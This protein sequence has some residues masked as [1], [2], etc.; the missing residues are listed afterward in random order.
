VPRQLAVT[1]IAP[2]KPGEAERLKLLLAGAGQQPAANAPISFE[3]FATT[4][5]ARFV[6][7]DAATGP[8]GATVPPRLAYMADVDAP[9]ARH[10]DDLVDIAAAGLDRIYGHCEDYP[11]GPGTTRAARLAY[12]RERQVAVAAIY[13]NTVG[14]TLRQIRQEARLR[15][16][17]Q[18]FIDRSGHEWAGKDPRAVRAAIQR[19]AYREESLRWARR[20]ARGLNLFDRLRDAAHLVAVPLLLLLLS[21]LIVLAL[22]IW[23]ALLRRRELADV[24]S[25]EKPS[26]ARIEELAAGE[27]RVVMNP[28]CGVGYVKPGRLR[29]WTAAFALWLVNYGARHLYNRGSLSGVTTIHF[30]R[31]VF[32]DGG[33]RLIFASNYDGSLESYMDDFIDKV[34]WG[35]NAVFSNGVGYPRTD[36]LVLGGA[37]DELAFKNYLR[38]RQLPVQLWYAAYDQLTAVNVANNARIRAGLYGRMDAEQAAAWLRLL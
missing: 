32:L 16:A 28:F 2:I 34:S 17:L 3:R 30:A 27:D 36:W 4:H 5:F 11:T 35:L 8:D 20:P 21:P 22:P 6:V 29:Y 18:A 31:W 25:R 14:R 13:V 12:L 10:L 38:T 37:R 24:P 15:D 26:A 9:L 33:R 1:I 19:F 7:L 23:L